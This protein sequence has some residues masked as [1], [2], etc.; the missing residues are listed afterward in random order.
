VRLD[1]VFTLLDV[2]GWCQADQPAE[3]RTDLCEHRWAVL[4]AIE[5]MALVAADELDEVDTERAKRGEPPKRSATLNRA[6]TP[7][8]T[9]SRPIDTRRPSESPLPSPGIHACFITCAAG[10]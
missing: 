7:A 9:S 4:R 6:A 5:V 10:R 8:R 2:V 3:V 1:R